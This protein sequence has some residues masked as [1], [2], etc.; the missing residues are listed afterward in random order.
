MKGV[1]SP[2]IHKLVKVFCQIVHISTMNY[3][4]IL[5]TWSSLNVRPYSLMVS[6]PFLNMAD[7]DMAHVSSFRSVMVPGNVNS[8]GCLLVTPTFNSNISRIKIYHDVFIVQWRCIYRYNTNKNNSSFISFQYSS[9]LEVSGCQFRLKGHRQP[10]QDESSGLFFK[11]HR[12]EIHVI[13]S[14]A[15]TLVL[16]QQLPCL[17]STMHWISQIDTIMCCHKQYNVGIVPEPCITITIL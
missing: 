6:S 8:F 15:L 1:V 11:A 4:Y 2:E 13:L 7:P 14:L 12:L 17:H 3:F 16:Q 5:L 9:V 10:W